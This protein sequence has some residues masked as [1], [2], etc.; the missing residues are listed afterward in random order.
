VTQFD[1]KISCLSDDLAIS[2]GSS[3]LNDTTF[4]LRSVN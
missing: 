2:R 4:I 3:M 1:V